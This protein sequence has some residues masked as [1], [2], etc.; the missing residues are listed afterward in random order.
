MSRGLAWFTGIIVTIVLIVGL[1]LTVVR[2]HD[3]PIEILSGGPFTSG[4]V[5]EA[6]DDWSH[7]EAEMTV[8]M[9]TMLPPRSRTMWLIVQNNRPYI[10]S[11]Y[12]NTV[13]G[14]LWKQ[15]P[16]KTSEDKRAL[17]RHDDEIYQVSLVRI[18]DSGEAEPVLEAFNEKYGTAYD[19]QSLSSGN[20]WLFEL[21][22]GFDP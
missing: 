20:A 15:W 3:G 12:M 2:T 16:R 17:I 18:F 19:A 5:V 1:T 9:Q 6:V 13:I 8:E 4:T 7:L 10:I 11:S 14:K 22:P 21:T